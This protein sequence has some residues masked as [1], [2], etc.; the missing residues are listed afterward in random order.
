VG[1]GSIAAA[2]NI[3]PVFSKQQQSD[4]WQVVF[5]A[6]DYLPNFIQTSIITG[7][8]I[9]KDNPEIVRGY[10]R[11]RAK[12]V[13]YLQDNVEEAAR[14][15]ASYND[16]Y[17]EEVMLQ[18]LKNVEPN[19]YYTTGEFNLDGLKLIERGMKNIDL[20]DRNIEWTKLI[21]QSFLSEDKRID[22]SKAEN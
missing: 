9:L 15:F 11:A 22:L 5:W 8:D 16:G 20:I 2:A 4:K 10:L 13:E 21:D 1:E 17:S 6:K 14:I 18:S 7:P 12:G 19:N 3:D